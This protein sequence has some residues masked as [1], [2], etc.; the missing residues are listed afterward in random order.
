[1]NGS[2][3]SPI[4]SDESRAAIERTADALHGGSLRDFANDRK[5]LA[6]E[7]RQAGNRAAA[8]IVASL[9]RPTLSAWLVNRL[10]RQARP[11]FDALF[12]AAARIRA[13]ELA[14]VPEQR[15]ALARLRSLAAEVL[16]ADGHAAADGTLARTSTTLQALAAAGSFDPDPPGRLLADRDPPG[17][18]SMA[19]LSLTG[20]PS[21]TL[22]PAASKAST[23]PEL[24]PVA[25]ESSASAR[26]TSKRTD[27][28]RAEREEAPSQQAARQ[29]TTERETRQRASAQRETAARATGQRDT[30]QPKT[31]Q[32]VASE[33]TAAERVAAEPAAAEHAA[34]QRAAA[35]HAAAERAAAEHAAAER[36]AA[37]LRAAAERARALERQRV[38]VELTNLERLAE[39]AR[40]NEHARSKTAED[41]RVALQRAES[42]LADARTQAEAATNTAAAARARLE[43]L[44]RDPEPLS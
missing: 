5:R 8:T 41:L 7:L 21:A 36:A 42:A 10:W 27:I 44:T 34:A 14:A 19:G 29:P 25:Q 16:R 6:T 28:Q 31:A 11:E 24:Q 20:P 35:E 22:A 23:A 40:R 37:A 26:Q 38:T 9:P 15:A 12:G 30:A 32:R 4:L 18:E 33:R 1:M 17:F 2:K 3:T 39:Q 13:G 43:A